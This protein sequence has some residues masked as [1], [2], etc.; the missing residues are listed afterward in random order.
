MQ[1]YILCKGYDDKEFHLIQLKHGK[2]AIIDK[3]QYKLRD[4]I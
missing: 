4:E 1:D 3:H 2:C